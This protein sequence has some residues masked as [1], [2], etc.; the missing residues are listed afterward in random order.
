W[1]RLAVG[2]ELEVVRPQHRPDHAQ[3]RAQD[4]VFVEAGDAVEPGFDLAD[5]RVRLGV[6]RLV[7]R[8]LEA[9]LEELDEPAREA[10]VRSE[11]LLHV[12][13]AEGAAGLPQVLRDRAQERDLAPVQLRAEHEAVEGV[14]LDG[15]APGLPES[16]LEE[17]ARA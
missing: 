14:V 10:G 12:G 15:A 16:V 13:L 9:Q 17:L 11:R 6:A 5:D 2:S 7:A 4:A 3:E 8:W 1:L